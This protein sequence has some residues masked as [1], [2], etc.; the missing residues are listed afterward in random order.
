MKPLLIFGLLFAAGA[1]IWKHRN[2]ACVA[3]GG[4]VTVTKTVV[5][6]SNLVP[7]GVSEYD[8]TPAP[9]SG[10]QV[11]AAAATNPYAVS[12]LGYAPAFGADENQP[13]WGELA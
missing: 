7:S 5:S 8:A 3:P 1:V 9:Q 11:H 13:G 4:I 2:A 6:E 10:Q 12:D